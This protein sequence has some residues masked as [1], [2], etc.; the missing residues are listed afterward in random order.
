M[1]LIL[2]SRAAQPATTGLFDCV[3]KTARTEGVGA[4]YKGLLPSLTSIIPY[5]GIGSVPLTTLIRAHGPRTTR[6]GSLVLALPARHIGGPP[7]LGSCAVGP[8]LRSLDNTR[9]THTRMRR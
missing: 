2:R 4:L 1:P 6:V 9:T 3:R 7:I 8:L 5:I